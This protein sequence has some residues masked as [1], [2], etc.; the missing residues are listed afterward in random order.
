MEDPGTHLASLLKTLYILLAL[1]RGAP[2]LK[3][4]SEQVDFFVS[5][6]TDDTQ[7]A[8]WIGWVLEEEG[9]SSVLQEWDFRPGSNFVLEMDRAVS[10]SRHTM[11][12][13]SPAY[14]SSHYTHPE[15]A[16]AFAQ[17]PTGEKRKLIPVR[18]EECVIEGLLSQIVY[19]D[20]VGRSEEEARD[21]LLQSLSGNRMRPDTRPGFPGIQEMERDE[22]P[23][24]PSKE[25]GFLDFVER[26]VKQL[27][28]AN[29]AALAFAGDVE[30][31]GTSAR[32]HAA[33]FRNAASQQGAHRVSR[34]KQIAR[35]AAREMKKFSRI[36]GKHVQEMAGLYEFGFGAW[37]GAL[38]LLPDFGSVDVQLLTDNLASLDGL[39]ASIPPTRENVKTLRDTTRRLPRV[40]GLFSVA[41]SQ[42]ASVLDGSIR[43]LDRVEFLA[44]KTRE[45]A[46]DLLARFDS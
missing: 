9:Y 21:K 5:Y 43:A 38:E 41:R 37:N 2:K 10:S 34:F 7:W 8:E 46:T 32:T 19:I 6:A 42:A 4:A 15:W 40:E 13:L 17:D 33:E 44:R 25:E 14:L 12:L 20:L 39:L 36:G 28:E 3:K 24:F 27:K 18:V 45:T 22:Y 26:G 29:S 30:R 11:P 31:L 35:S 1:L 16:A 23:S